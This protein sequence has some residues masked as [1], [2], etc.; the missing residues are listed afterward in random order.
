MA[1]L[2]L[3]QGYVLLSQTISTLD[4]EMDNNSCL[5]GEVIAVND[6]CELYAEDDIV[7]FDPVGCQIIRIDKMGTFVTYYL[8]REDNILLK[9]NP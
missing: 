2:I 7:L 3:K 1:D 6:L 9:E 5:F 4:L 8:V